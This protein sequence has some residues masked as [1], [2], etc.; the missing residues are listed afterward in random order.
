MSVL[1]SVVQGRSSGLPMDAVR[2]AD[3]VPTS[4]HLNLNPHFDKP[5][6]DSYAHWSLRGTDLINDSVDFGFYKWPKEKTNILYLCASWGT[7]YALALSWFARTTPA[8]TGIGLLWSDGRKSPEWGHGQ[9]RTEAEWRS[10]C[11]PHCTRGRHKYAHLKCVFTYALLASAQA[12]NAHLGEIEV[13]VKLKKRELL[14]LV[15]AG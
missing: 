15:W 11:G 14:L 6:G 3:S 12:A 13:S 1:C 8:L 10:A 7:R 4:G 9:G 2:K 5:T